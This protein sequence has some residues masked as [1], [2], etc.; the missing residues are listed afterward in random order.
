MPIILKGYGASK[1]GLLP[2]KGKIGFQGKHAG[3]PIWFRNIK[4]KEL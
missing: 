3:A 4:I 1:M 2:P